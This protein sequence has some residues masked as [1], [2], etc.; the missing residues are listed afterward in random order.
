MVELPPSQRSYE[1]PPRFPGVNVDISVSASFDLG[2]AELRDS[3]E[4]CCDLLTAVEFVD[5]YAE[6]AADGSRSL[7]VRL[8]FRSPDRTLTD[9]DIAT[10]MDAVRKS[11]AERGL[12]PLDDEAR[13]KVQS[14]VLNA[15]KLSM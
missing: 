2:F 12:T 13:A 1:P 15:S 8:C 11:L 4:G 14:N 10:E 6:G 7:T 5:E 9:D 3:L